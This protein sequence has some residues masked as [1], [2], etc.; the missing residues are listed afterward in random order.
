MTEFNITITILYTYIT[1]HALSVTI[2]STHREIQSEEIAIDN[3][4]IASFGS[5]KSVNS[6]IERFIRTNLDSDTSVFAINRYCNN[7]IKKI[8]YT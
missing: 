3:I 4:N 8:L 7:I 2:L 1:Y 5:S 6:S